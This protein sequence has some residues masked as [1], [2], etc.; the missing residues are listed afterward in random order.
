MNVILTLLTDCPKKLK[1][2]LFMVG[3]IGGND[4]NYAFSQGKTLEEVMN[5]QVPV[6]I[7]V[8]KDTVRVSFFVQ[9]YLLNCYVSFIA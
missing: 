9:V 2:S 8:I 7:Q 6:V 1:N 4:Y 3:E 5:E